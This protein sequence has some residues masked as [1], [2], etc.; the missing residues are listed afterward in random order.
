MFIANQN[1]KMSN[2]MVHRGDLF[3]NID[4]AYVTRGLV[5]EIKII[6]PETPIVEVSNA[7]QQFEPKRRGRK[8]KAKAQ[9]DYEPND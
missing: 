1:F 6:Q 8:S 3:D 9:Q 4:S 2:R 7:N 5:R